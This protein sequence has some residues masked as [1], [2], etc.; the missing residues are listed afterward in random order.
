MDFR[1]GNTERNIWVYIPTFDFSPNIQCL[2]CL[3]FLTMNL[4]KIK[5]WVV[6][7]II[8]QEA[9]A[10]QVT[11]NWGKEIIIFL[12]IFNYLQIIQ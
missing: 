11:K 4:L 5:A 6:I 8:L 3:S 10:D 2:P 9:D 12:Q 1:L 7:L